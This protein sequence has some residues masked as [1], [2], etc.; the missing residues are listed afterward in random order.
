[1]RV[2]PWATSCLTVDSEG[3]T[4]H[5]HNPSALFQE[6]SE[7]FSGVGLGRSLLDAGVSCPLLAAGAIETPEL[8]APEI[9]VGRQEGSQRG[10]GHQDPSP[11][12]HRFRWGQL[13]A[14]SS[15]PLGPWSALAS[16]G[17]WRAPH[18]PSC[19]PRDS[20]QYVSDPACSASPTL[21]VASGERSWL[22]PGWALALRSR[23]G[24]CDGWFWVSA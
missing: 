6:C 13:G 12:N 15:G 21:S 8:A 4:S 1:M 11:V 22:G 20:C 16:S 7:H 19:H 10:H 5:L 3:D 2:L 9:G 24:H 17:P 23:L 18:E 14:P